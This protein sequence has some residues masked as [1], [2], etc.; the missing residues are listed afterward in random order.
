MYCTSNHDDLCRNECSKSPAAERR[1]QEEQRQRSILCSVVQAENVVLRTALT[2]CID[3]VDAGQQAHIT[4]DNSIAS[5]NAMII[6]RRLAQDA[7]GGRR[8]DYKGTP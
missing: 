7:L 3:V 6:V 5:Y 2:K 4:T 1:A 8:T